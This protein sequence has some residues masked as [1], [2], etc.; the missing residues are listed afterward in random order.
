[1][2]HRLLSVSAALLFSIALSAVRSGIDPDP[3]QATESGWLEATREELRSRINPPQ[4]QPA[5]DAVAFGRRTPVRIDTASLEPNQLGKGGIPGLILQPGRKKKTPSLA[6]PGSLHLRA[7]LNLGKR[8]SIPFT[9]EYHL[10]RES[11]GKLPPGAIRR[12]GSPLDEIYKTTNETPMETDAYQEF[13]PPVDF[14][15]CA[16]IQMTLTSGEIF[17]ASA[18]LILIGAES[19]G[20][21]GPEIFGMASEPEETLEFA[22]PMAAAGRAV[23]AIRVIFRHNPMAASHSTRVA[24]QR[25]TFLPRGL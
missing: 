7:T 25:F 24:V 11:S 13:D 22:V 18:A 15:P 6:L 1:V 19:V 21:L 2:L 4:P 5:S 9:G 14:A 3:F 20:E 12:P 17:P 8:L 10:F 16:R 23:K